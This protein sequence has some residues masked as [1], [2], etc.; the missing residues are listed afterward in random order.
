[1]RTANHLMSTE[2]GF[3]IPD[4]VFDRL[5][6]QAQR[7]ERASLLTDRREQRVALI[8]IEHPRDCSN[9]HYAHIHAH[10]SLPAY[11]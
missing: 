5:L 7:L 4:V 8:A 1:V 11:S 2:P 10:P 3:R 9:A 6:R